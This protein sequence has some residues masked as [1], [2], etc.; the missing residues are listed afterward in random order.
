MQQVSQQIL[1]R[2][3]LE[4]IILEFGLYAEERRHAVMEDVVENMRK[5]VAITPQ[6]D[7]TLRVAF[8]GGDARTVVKVTQRLVSLL[9]QA[10]MQDREKLAE[11]TDEF[12]KGQIERL[13][14]RLIEQKQQLNAARHSGSPQAETMAIEY[15]VLQTTFKDLLT[16]QEDAR[17]SANL[18]RRQIG[19]QLRLIEPPRVAERPFSPDRRLYAGIGAVAGLAAAL[20]LSLVFRWTRLRGTTERRAVPAEA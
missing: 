18:E 16:K 17:M 7:S 14:T 6:S 15:D 2:T 5:D 4:N 12:I 11:Q 9:I 3:T 19:E 1:S 10:H 20:L 13:R 8:V